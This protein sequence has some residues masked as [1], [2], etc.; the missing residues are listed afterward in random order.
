MRDHVMLASWFAA[1]WFAGADD[2]T[3][4]RVI[5]G[6]RL[7]P[8]QTAPEGEM[9]SAG[10]GL[11]DRDLDEATSVEY[12]T[13]GWSL[14]DEAFCAS[15]LINASAADVWSV[16]SVPGVT[17]WHPH[18]PVCTEAPDRSDSACEFGGR[19]T[20][21]HRDAK[22]WDLITYSSSQRY[23]R[24][25]RNWYEGIGFNVDVG[26]YISEGNFPVARVSWRLRDWPATGRSELALSAVGIVESALDRPHFKF[27][28][29]LFKAGDPE[30]YVR[31]I[32]LGIK[33]FVETG[34]RPE[35]DQF[36]QS[37][38]YSKGKFVNAEYYKE[39]LAN[40]LQ[41]GHLSEEE[42]AYVLPAIEMMTRR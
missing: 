22:A 14:A 37:R 11:F 12:G 5:E 24:F 30:A 31:S 35:P 6:T 7:Q 27:L 42:A 38:T 4:Q 8:W 18:A 16:I 41:D 29:A 21:E 1:A 36:G 25:V 33:Q 34:K 2:S 39:A 40:M 15:A 13:F 32:V 20:F 26:P 28:V 3:T 9:C 23:K 10:P 17:R 19:D